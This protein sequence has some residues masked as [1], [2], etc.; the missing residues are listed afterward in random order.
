MAT[1]QH[2]ETIAPTAE[3]AQLALQ[4]S[5][6]LA[7]LAGRRTREVQLQVRAGDKQTKTDAVS[8]PASAFRM[9]VEILNQMAQGNA[10]TLIPVHA[11]LTTQQAAELLNVSRPFVIKLIE[12]EVLPCKMVGTHRR[13]LF[14]DLMQYKRTIDAER[15][16]VLEELA[17]QAQELGMGY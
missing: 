11:E 3:D 2:P 12:D 14:S 13:V 17:A 10:V 6:I 4:S 5:R 15:L 7:R 8:I 9:L 1:A 16:K